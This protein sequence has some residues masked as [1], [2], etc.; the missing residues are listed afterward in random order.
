MDVN[1]QSILQKNFYQAGKG[2]TLTHQNYRQCMPRYHSSPHHRPF[3][4]QL[5]HHSSPPHL[6]SPTTSLLPSTSLH[7]HNSS[8]HTKQFFLIVNRTQPSGGCDEATAFPNL[9]MFTD[10]AK[11]CTNNMNNRPDRCRKV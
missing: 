9:K 5:S 6:F 3:P 8:Q 7:N 4:P 1:Q 10:D 11:R 2:H